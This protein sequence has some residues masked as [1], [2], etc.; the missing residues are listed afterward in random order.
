[1]KRKPKPRL[2]HQVNAHPPPKPTTPPTQHTNPFA[3]ILDAVA[4]LAEL[5][6]TNI[7]R[8]KPTTKKKPPQK[9]QT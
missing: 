4:D 3:R 1:M 8:R 7:L 5:F 6:A 9:P 2:V